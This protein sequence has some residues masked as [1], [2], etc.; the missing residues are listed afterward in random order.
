ML[1]QLIAKLYIYIYHI[2]MVW[3]GTVQEAR[4]KKGCIIFFDE[5]DAIGGARYFDGAGGDYEV[6]RTM[7]EIVNKLDG[8]ENLPIQRYQI[9][10]D[11]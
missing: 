6:Q 11:K 7:L 2:C 9:K 5:V 1:H 3:Y 4:S 8:L 10:S